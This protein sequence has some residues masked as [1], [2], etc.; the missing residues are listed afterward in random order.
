M[1]KK[2]YLKYWQKEAEEA[3]KTAQSLFNL[4]RFNHCLFFCHL[5]I[6]K[7]IKGLIVKKTNQHPFPI[8]N[9]KKLAS[10]AELKIGQAEQKQLEEITTWNIKARYDTIKQDFHKKATKN[11]TQSWLKKVKELFLWLEKQY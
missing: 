4:E 11:F 5:A 7:I 3:L 9:L 8:H 6:E 2:E 10:Q 1:T